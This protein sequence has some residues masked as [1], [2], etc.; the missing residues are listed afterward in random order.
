MKYQDRNPSLLKYRK[1]I[2]KYG[3]AGP[4][5]MAVMLFKE[6][7]TRKG[8]LGCVHH[9][10]DGPFDHDFG[11]LEMYVD[12]RIKHETAEEKRLARIK[13][14][15]EWNA[16]N[17]EKF[18]SYRKKY[19]KTN[20][21]YRERRAEKSKTHW[22]SLTDEQREIRKAKQRAWYASLTPEQKKE[23]IRRTREHTLLRKEKEKDD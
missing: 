6:D 15:M 4:N 12:K 17:P 2:C 18:E 14:Q 22:K 9:L 19:Y 7:G 20:E 11:P 16:R 8:C 10:P 5:G 3:H 21:A 13:S 1:K 23:R